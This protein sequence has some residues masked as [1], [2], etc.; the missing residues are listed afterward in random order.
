MNGDREA[1]RKL[2]EDLKA[3]YAEMEF[4]EQSAVKE[5]LLQMEVRELIGHGN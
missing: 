5:T 2:L 1:A 4:D 3:M